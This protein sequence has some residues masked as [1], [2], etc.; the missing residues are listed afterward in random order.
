M[1]S[2]V[3]SERSSRPSETDDDLVRVFLMANTLETGGTERQFVTMAN[4]L[5][6]Q[7]AVNPGCLK[8]VGPFVNEV[9]GLNEFSPGGT[10][11]GVKS[12]QARLNLARF[13]RERRVE[14]A[15]SF[16]FYSNLMLAPAARFARIPAVFGS[17]RQLGDLL[18]AKQ[19]RAQ[20]LAFRLCDRVVCNSKAAAGRLE[21]AGV[22]PSKL[23]VIPNALREESFAK[24][25]PALAVRP[26]LLRVGMI[27]R[28]NDPV[29]RHDLFLRVAARLAPEFPH[30]EFVL[31]G[32]GPLQPGLQ[33]LAGQ[34]GLSD[35]V[36]FL[37]DRRDIPAV[38]ASLDI[39]VLPSAS[40]SLSNVILESMAAGV[41][42][43]AS[44]IGGNVELIESGKSGLLF[45]SG[46]EKAF[47]TELAR[48]LTHADLRKALGDA[49]RERAQSGYSM[50]AIKQQYQ[51]L[52]RQ[53][54]S[55][56]RR[57]NP[58]RAAIRETESAKERS[59]R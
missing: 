10:L 1:N 31:I 9:K 13:L 27:S 22:R 24:T 48:L 33:Q 50:N 2:S 8:R 25:A 20:K 56:K 45:S 32:D 49:A 34:L 3:L 7:F 29:K 26:G 19:F 53:V 51:R 21:S 46:D 52:Y 30:A 54:L 28:M 38:L 37:G 58:S 55:E 11:Y 43:L 5:Q 47:A 16:D 12:W 14:I 36:A 17:H 42:V 23:A 59:S 40:E 39:S 4:A 44:A 57:E 41:A 6:D 18:T 15:H 35:R